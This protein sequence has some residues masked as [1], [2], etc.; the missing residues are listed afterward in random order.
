MPSQK[1]MIV[2]DHP[3]I[4]RVLRQIFDD[5]KEFDV[6]AEAATAAE[7]LG[8]A[9]STLPQLAI[10][11]LRLPD[12][13]GIELIPLLLAVSPATRILVF[14]ANDDRTHSA[15]ARKAG[16]HGFINKEKEAAELLAGARLVLAGYTCFTSFGNGQGDALLSMR[17]MAVLKQLVRGATNVEIAES[18]NLSPKTVSTYKTRVFTKLKLSSV[19]ELVEYAKSNGL[20]D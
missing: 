13:D 12:Q 4:R 10:I 14:S 17:E 9:R 7:A 5:A 19:I 6:V 1:L 16:A 18:L 8:H 3:V 20:A 11:D 15:L 2:D